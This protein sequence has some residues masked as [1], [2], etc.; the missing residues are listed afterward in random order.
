MKTNST[1]CPYCKAK[2]VL[3]PASTVYGVSARSAGRHLYVCSNWPKCDA[4]V[5][6]HRRDK[7]PMGNLAN[8]DLRH[9]RILAHKALDEY[10]KLTHMEKWAV[11]IWLQGKLGM[12]ENQLHIAKFSEEMCDQVIALC[13]DAIEHY[14]SEK[15]E[16]IR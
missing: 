6:A 4:Y 10:R 5:S 9:K 2:A 14:L 11:Y 1:I 12:S 3:R 7:R 13:S 15:G 8:G 16:M